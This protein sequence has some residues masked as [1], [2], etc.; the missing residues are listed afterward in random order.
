MS[1][2]AAEVPVP[3]Q[4]AVPSPEAGAEA[5]DP[6]GE[7][8]RRLEDIISTYG[9][10]AAVLDQQVTPNPTFTKNQSRPTCA[11]VTSVSCWLN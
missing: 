3:P 2:K 9:A 8:N 7:F 5:S 10:A 6:L 4:P 1:L 11:H